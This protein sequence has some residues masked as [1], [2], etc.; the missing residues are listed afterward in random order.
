MCIGILGEIPL[1]LPSSALEFTKLCWLIIGKSVYVNGRKVS[2]YYPHYI[3]V[4][5]DILYLKNLY[6]INIIIK[7]INKKRFVFYSI[8]HRGALKKP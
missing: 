8:G 6:I 3:I 4:I 5:T 2:R 7:F 1:I